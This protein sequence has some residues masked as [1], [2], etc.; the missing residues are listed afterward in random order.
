VPKV[1]E[2]LRLAPRESKDFVQKNWQAVSQP[3]AH[4]LPSGP[5]STACMPARNARR[6]RCVDGAARGSALR[7]AVM[8]ATAQR[9]TA[10]RRLALGAP[11]G[12]LRPLRSLV[13]G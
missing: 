10:K 9:S 4:C 3:T 11:T 13:V 12:G 6:R 7:H 5:R 1:S 2:Q 8:C